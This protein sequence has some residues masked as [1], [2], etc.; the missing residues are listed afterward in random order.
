MICELCGKEANEGFRVRLEGSLVSACPMCAKMGEVVS[1]VRTRVDAKPK[2]KAAAHEPVDL[3]SEVGVEYDLADD[4]GARVKAA[5]E[6]Q[7][8]TQEE[9]GRMVNE[10]HSLI[11]RIELGRFEPP[12]DLA[13]RLERRLGVRLLAPHMEYDEVKPKGEAGAVTLGDLVVVRKRSR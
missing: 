11:H 7:G 9:L 4:F 6:K 13:R 10:P 3:E 8:W 2:P 5:R 12:V 1:P